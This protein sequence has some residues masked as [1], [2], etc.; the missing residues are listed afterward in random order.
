ML[1]NKTAFIIWVFLAI[2][3]KVTATEN[4]S[5][6][7][8][9]IYPQPPS[10]NNQLSSNLSYPEVNVEHEAKLDSVHTLF[11]H[12]DFQTDTDNFQAVPPE[13]PTPVT[14]SSSDVNRINCRD[15]V[16]DVATSSEKGVL[17][18]I[19]GK[20]V[21]IKFT[22]L[23]GFDGKIKYSTTPTELFVVCGE[24]TYNLVIVPKQVPS[25][26]I[27][28]GTGAAHRI[29]ANQELYATLP[30]ERK[31]LRAI[32]DVYTEQMPDSYQIIKIDRSVGNYQEFSIRHRRSIV[33]EGEGLVLQEFELALK[34][35]QKEFK[36]N[37]RI[38]VNKM[39]APNIVAICPERSILYPGEITRLFIIE[40]RNE[41][42]FSGFT[43]IKALEST[44]SDAKSKHPNEEHT[45]SPSDIRKKLVR[46]VA[47]EN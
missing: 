34:P 20:D 39:F 44:E 46:E 14:M 22:I 9:V 31:I 40:Q 26:T 37:D 7:Q 1:R 18:K 41:K 6:A 19:V 5:S 43:S 25:R 36:L 27:R 28:L 33:I 12:I 35:G 24:S 32:K 30:F 47:H 10:V 3:F 29:K 15:E 13:A 45:S 8:A 2:P 17:V 11:D 23:K 38:F 42:P 4:K 16:R 21:F